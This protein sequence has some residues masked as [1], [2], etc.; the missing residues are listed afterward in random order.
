MMKK[1]LAAV[2]ASVL[3]LSACG[4]GTGGGYGGISAYR[5]VEPGPKRVARERMQVTP[6]IPWNRAPRSPQEI[7][8]E[9]NW[10]LNGPHLDNLTFIGGVKSGEPLVRNQRRSDWR[11]VPNFRADMP[12]TDII[13]I[14]ETFYRV[15]GGSVSF[16]TKAVQPRDFSAGPASSSIMSGSAGMKCGGSARRRGGDR[17]PALH[18]PVRRRGDALFPQRRGRGRADHLQRAPALQRVSAAPRGLNRF[19][20]SRPA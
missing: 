19:C 18:D 17:R 3:A 10:T 4:A 7:T 20:R 15:R 12:P 1:Q 5:L 13:G 14:V 11:Q 2:L 16:E 6:G 8:R 9:E